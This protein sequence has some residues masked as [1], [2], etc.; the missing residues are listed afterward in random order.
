MLPP[1]VRAFRDRFPRRRTVHGGHVDRGSGGRPARR[2]IGA[3][4][5]RPPL[6]DTGVA[7]VPL[8]G[9]RAETVVAWPP[10]NDRPVLQ[11]LLDVVMKLAA[12][13]D[14]TRSG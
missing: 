7:F 3:A 12:G 4:L 11:H 10:R 9:D 2:Q 13:T 5:T 6:R 14:L 1:L 8:R